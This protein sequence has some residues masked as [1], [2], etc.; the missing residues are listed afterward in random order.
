MARLSRAELQERTRARVLSAARDEFAERGFREA[1][2]D[3]IAERADLT[4]GAVYSNFPGKRALYFAVLAEAIPEAIPED[5]GQRGEAPSAAEA[6]RAFARAWLARLPL[7][8][9]EAP[10][11]LG[12]DLLAEVQSD[13]LTRVPYTE[14]MRLDALLLGLAL[15][16]LEPGRRRVGLAG[17][18]L[19]LL[20]GARQ[21]AAAAPGFVDPF[22]TAAAVAHLAGLELDEDRPPPHL[23]WAPQAG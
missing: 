2:I 18:A 12:A 13:E 9:E 10:G 15:E 11:R 8:A 19:T 1:R 6:L 14:L 5:T 3:S 21:L 22:H 23:A 16:R 7:S 4:R 17:A 20:Q